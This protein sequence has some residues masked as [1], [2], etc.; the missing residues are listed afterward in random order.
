MAEYLVVAGIG[1]DSKGPLFRTFDR[2]RQLT[3]TRMH[4]SDVL[5]MVKRHAGHAA[6]T[7]RLCYHA[8]RATGITA[9]LLN[10]GTIENAARIAA[11]ES[12]R[13]TQLYNHPNDQVPNKT[14]IPF[15]L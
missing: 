14:D 3:A 8:W 4:A 11:H 13:T 5:R 6:L 15:S 1:H 9:Y 12:T 10:G 7:G 2:R